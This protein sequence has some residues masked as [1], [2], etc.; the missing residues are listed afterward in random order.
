MINILIVVLCVWATMYAN[1]KLLQP[2]LIDR[3][4]FKLF[5]LRDELALLA[6]SGRIAPDS[7]EYS[8]ICSLINS[9]IK[10][11]KNI[12]PICF[13]QFLLQVK[14]GKLDSSFEEIS[15]LADE[16]QDAGVKNIVNEYFE[17]TF[18]IFRFNTLLIG[19]LVIFPLAMLKRW[20]SNI[21]R[22]VKKYHDASGY[23]R[24]FA[25]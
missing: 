8:A 6:M 10:R 5:A 22:W 12:E 7:T 15:R 16:L 9:T 25:H 11:A 14:A 2:A 17:I 3:Y 23:I 24:G 20:S 13:I 4:R 1:N 19:T 18:K 21:K